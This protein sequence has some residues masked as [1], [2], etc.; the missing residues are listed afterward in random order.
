MDDNIAYPRVSRRIQALM[1]D[2]LI[3]PALAVGAIFLARQ[4]GAEGVYAA[5][6]AVLVIFL[7]EPVLVSATGGTLGHHMMGIRVCDWRRG[8]NLSIIAA[9]I[10]FL[11][12]LALGLFSTVSLFLTRQHQAIHDLLTGSIVILKHP[13]RLPAH[14]ILREREVETQGYRYPPAWRRLLMILIYNVLFIYLLSGFEMFLFSDHCIQYN[15]CSRIDVGV[16]AV[17]SILWFIGA[18]AGTA[19]CWRG[20]LPGCRRRPLD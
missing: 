20:R 15:L 9:V 11:A 14:E 7:L 5:V 6:T 18:I 13:E 12:K 17:L 19:Q 16:A 4:L 8:G 3:V 2:G 1:L 10:R